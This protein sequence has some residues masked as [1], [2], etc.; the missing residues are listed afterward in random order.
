[1]A[2]TNPF[3]KTVAPAPSEPV[4]VDP[5]KAAQ[6]LGGSVRQ[7][8]VSFA[9]DL[10]TANEYA[11]QADAEAQAAIDEAKARQ[12]IAREEAKANESLLS[13]LANLGVVG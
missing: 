2:L 8:F 13:G 11:A 12:S 9:S 4:K 6:R 7:Q 3:K 10:R 1:M 5:L